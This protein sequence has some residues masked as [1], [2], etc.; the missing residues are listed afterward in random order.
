MIASYYYYWEVR[1]PLLNKYLFWIMCFCILYQK[2]EFA[3]YNISTNIYNLRIYIC[4]SDSYI[5]SKYNKT[6]GRAHYFKMSTRNL[7]KRIK[8][9]CIMKFYWAYSERLFPDLTTSGKLSY[10]FIIKSFSLPLHRVAT[11]FWFQD[12]SQFLTFFLSFWMLTRW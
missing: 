8:E 4:I 7:G 1:K 5:Y 9:R 2:I 12:I 6:N 3:I 10:A 11:S